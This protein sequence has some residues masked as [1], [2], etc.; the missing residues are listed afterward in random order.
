MGNPESGNKNAERPVYLDCAATT[1]IEP[2][3]ADEVLLYMS[4]EYGNAGSRT[5]EWGVRAKRRVQ[6]AREQ[7][8]GLV[9]CATDEVV[10]TSGAT[11]A[12]NLA[13]L[14]LEPYARE[15]GRTHVITTAIEH[16]AVLE[17][18]ARLGARGFDVSVVEPDSEGSVN[19]HE[20][21]QH[22]RDDTVLVSVMLVNNET[23]VI[24]P[25]DEIS[26]V[27]AEHDAYLHVDAVQGVAKGVTAARNSRIDLLSLSGHKLFAPKG[28]G[29]LVAR[30]RGYKRVPLTPLMVGGGQER[31]LRAGT[32]PTALIA[33]LGLAAEMAVK[34]V[35]QRHVACKAFGDALVGALEPLN[36]VING[37]AE[38]VPDILNVSLTGLDSEAA[39][40][41]SKREIAISNGAACTSQ[42]YD[43]SH[44]LTAMGLPPERIA[45]AL[46][47]SWCHLTPTPDWASVLSAWQSVSK[48]VR[49]VA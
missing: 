24:Q 2:L 16:K 44:V 25:I 1:P 10:F 14:G 37:S 32:A 27:L 35:V 30:R 9:G 17:P 21:A 20:I 8:A 42:S 36:P 33:G 41:A 3:V 47:F 18:L 48:P 29:A 31:G 26:G 11:E 23:G 22:L 43:A 28:I 6:E 5:H 13:L 34:D 49:E 45:S 46:R 15:S 7:V 19:A 4:Q 12:N 40:V 38:R 39:I